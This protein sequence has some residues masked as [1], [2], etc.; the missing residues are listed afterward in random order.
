MLDLR[1]NCETKISGPSGSIRA[2]SLVKVKD[3][4]TAEKKTK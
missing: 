2:R 3:D 4:P 1:L